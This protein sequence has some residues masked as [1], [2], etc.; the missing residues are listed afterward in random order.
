MC[1][2]HF[3]DQGHMTFTV[4]Y[5]YMSCNIRNF[6]CIFKRKT[7]DISY[8]IRNLMCPV[9]FH[10]QGH[11]TFTVSYLCR[12]DPGNMQEMSWNV[13][14]MSPTYSCR[15]FPQNAFC[16]SCVPEMHPMHQISCVQ[17]MCLKCRLY[18]VLIFSFMPPYL[19]ISNVPEMSCVLATGNVPEVSCVLATG[20][21]PEILPYTVQENVKEISKFPGVGNIHTMYRK[22]ELS[23]TFHGISW[24]RKFRISSSGKCCDFCPNFGRWI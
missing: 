4:H 3:P 21:L 15:R 20:H 10:D 9:H 16:L 2:V 23:W 22:Y 19:V 7:H 8:V 14:E 17:E 24:H 1:P 6:M 11:V 18:C 12:P 13:Q 5:L